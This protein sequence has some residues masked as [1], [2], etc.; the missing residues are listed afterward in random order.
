MSHYQHLSIEERESIWEN[1]IK[2]KNIREIAKHLGRSPS[3]VSRELKRNQSPQGYRPSAAQEQY[4]MRRSRSRR[5]RLLGPGPLRDTVVRLL[6]QQQWSPEQIAERLAVERG[7]RQVS[8]STIYRAL[9]DGSME[10]KGSRKNRYGRYPMQK[11]LRRKGWRGTK[12]KRETA[13]FVHQTI[14]ERPE[15]AEKRRQFG[16]FEGDLVYSSFHKLYVVTLVDRRSRYLLTGICRSK[17]PAEV[18]DVLASI[19]ETLPK[20]KLRS[21]TLDRGQEFAFHGN[22]SE[23]IPN[24]V[25]YFAHPYSTWERG[26]NENINGLLRQYIPKN[27]YKV[28]LSPELLVQ[29]TDKLNHRPRKCLNWKSPLEVFF[30]KSLH[31]T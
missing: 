30:H 8:Y 16:H 27:T 3:T 12:K 7:E 2:G 11:Y 13:S 31:L 23:K 4:Q 21:V 24:A 19:L 9:K 26:T 20:K 1:R 28:P 14:E 17:K 18:A 5:R 6:T 25:F 10:P 29:F 22:I 15:A